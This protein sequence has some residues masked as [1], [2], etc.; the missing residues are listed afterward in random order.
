MTF[1]CGDNAALVSYLYGECTPAEQKAVAAHLPAC[2]ACTAELAAL[3]S[4]RL[5]LASWIPPEADSGIPDRVRGAP[6][7]RGATGPVVATADAGLGAG[8][9]RRRAV[10]RRAVARRHARRCPAGDVNDGRPPSG[11]GS[12]TQRIPL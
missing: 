12:H 4:T 8:G 1:E 11:S 9:G 7:E 3:S 5:Q 10:W 2:P 6:V